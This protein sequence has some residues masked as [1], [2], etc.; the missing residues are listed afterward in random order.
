[1]TEYKT[2]YS[3]LKSECIDYL[4]NVK[5]DHS[6][7]IADF[8]FGAGG[9]TLEFCSKVNVGHVFAFDQDIEAIQNGRSLIEKNDLL[10]RVTLIHSNFEF[11]EGHL[12]EGVELDG[13]LIDL[14]V[15]SHQFDSGERG[16]SFRYDAPLD[17]RMNI[18]D[19]NTQSAADLLRVLSQEELEE[20]FWE[21]GED[22]YSKR[23]AKKI[24]DMRNEGKLINTTLEL[25]D[26][27]FHCYPKADRFT[28]KSPSTKIFQALRIAVND[29]LGVL[30]RVIAKAIKKLRIGGRLAIISFHS[31]EDRIVKNIFKDFE[32]EIEYPCR[33]LTK[34][35]ILPTS[36]EILENSR[37]RSAKLRVLE[38]VENLKT[39]NKYAH[40]PVKE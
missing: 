8:T 38:R 13:I 35:P 22:K 1:M 20:I 12:S 6:L 11:F 34:K 15:S 40:R 16:F 5:S 25:E 7:Q 27:I 26:V 31:L 4:T 21:Y 18:E 9:H 10:S 30:E 3:V 14:G 39:K 33:I 32:K 19:S 2:H 17:M 24:V 28:G 36:S 23:I 29:E 37:S